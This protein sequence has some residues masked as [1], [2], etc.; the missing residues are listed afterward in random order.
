MLDEA[1]VTCEVFEDNWFSGS[2]VQRWRG[3]V[4]ARRT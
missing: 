4:A 2:V 3:R 1:F